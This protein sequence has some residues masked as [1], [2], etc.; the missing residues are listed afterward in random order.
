MEGCFSF[1]CGNLSFLLRNN[2]IVPASNRLT[3]FLLQ[4]GNQIIITGLSH[5]FPKGDTASMDGVGGSVI[6]APAWLGWQAKAA[7]YHP[8]KIE[9]SKNYAL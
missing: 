2:K 4:Y 3:L 9:I 5:R 8:S 6:L 1:C 7:V